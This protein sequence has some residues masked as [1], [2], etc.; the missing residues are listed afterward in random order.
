M[1]VRTFVLGCCLL[2]L[3]LA[4]L[5]C[6]A[7]ACFCWLVTQEPSDLS[8]SEAAGA[9]AVYGIAIAAAYAATTTALALRVVTLVVAQSASLRGW[10]SDGLLAWRLHAALL[11]QCGCGSLL[12]P[13]WYASRA[14]VRAGLAVS[15]FGAGFARDADTQ[16]GL[17]L[18]DAG[19]SFYDDTCA[20]TCSAA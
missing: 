8:R 12:K 17:R 14:A 13:L 10:A 19:W 3:Q 2:L 11:V 16:A 5:A 1:G 18:L 4:Q 15:F 7:L 20:S 9:H 6:L